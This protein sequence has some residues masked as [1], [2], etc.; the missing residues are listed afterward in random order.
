[1]LIDDYFFRQRLYLALNM[2]N[3]ENYLGVAIK[4][5]ASKDYTIVTGSSNSHTLT[6]KKSAIA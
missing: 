4:I 2:K 5:N 6:F 1:M 3:L